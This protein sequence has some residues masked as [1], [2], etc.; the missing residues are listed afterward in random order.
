MTEDITGWESFVD[1][2]QPKTED[3]NFELSA[4]MYDVSVDGRIIT[5]TP[6]EEPGLALKITKVAENEYSIAYDIHGV[7]VDR[8]ANVTKAQLK[9]DWE[10]PE[11]IF[12]YQDKIIEELK[13]E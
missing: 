4:I 13:N 8:G 12:E 11:E 9:A 1:N 7:F 2:T 5:M 6:M 3:S 10:L